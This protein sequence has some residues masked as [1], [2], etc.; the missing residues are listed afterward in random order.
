VSDYLPNFVGDARLLRQALV[1]IVGNALKY[2]KADGSVA[3]SARLEGS[4]LVVRVRDTGIGIAKEDVSRIFDKFFR[5][6]SAEHSRVH[7]TGLGLPM[8][9]YIVERHGG[10]IEVTSE[11]GVGSEFVV[12]LPVQS[13]DLDGESRESSLMSVD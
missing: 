10:R 3:L 13:A 2:T 8:A 1:N 5:A 7:G 4:D 6:G 12:F 9:R 11:I